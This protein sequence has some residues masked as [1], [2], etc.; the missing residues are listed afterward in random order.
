MGE[1]PGKVGAPVEAKDPEQIRA[2]IES[3]RQEL[4]DTVE[5]LAEKAD[6]KKHARERIERTKASIPAPAAIGVVAAVA[7]VGL[8]LIVRR[9]RR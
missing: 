7:V 9:T 4:G 2:E 5:A 8:F 1:D 6:V 3:T